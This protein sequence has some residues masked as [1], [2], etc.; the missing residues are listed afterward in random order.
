MKTLAKISSVFALVLFITVF[1]TSETSA[2]QYGGGKKANKGFVD[3]NGDGINDNALDADGDGI[4]NGQDADFVRPQDGSGSKNMFGKGSGKKGLG[5][6]NGTGICD[7]TGLGS[8]NGS[9]TGV[10]DGTGNGSNGKGR[11]RK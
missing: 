3:V 2:Q 11:G 7:G 1:F 4:P 8:G 6:G 5:T 9:G 10:C